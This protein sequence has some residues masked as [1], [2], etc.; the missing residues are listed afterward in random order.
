PLLKEVNLLELGLDP[1]EVLEDIL[2]IYYK[3]FADCYVAHGDFNEH[4]L[5]WH[6]NQIFVIDVLQARKYN[7]NNISPFASKGNYISKIEAYELLER[8]ITSI[9]RHFRQKYSVSFD[10]K[11]VIE[12]MMDLQDED[13]LWYQ[14]FQYIHG[15]RHFSR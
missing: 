5:I 9:M 13:S 15:E 14:T 1:I 10:T 4:N 12:L 7:S 2:D 11:E 8:D 6:N 3:I